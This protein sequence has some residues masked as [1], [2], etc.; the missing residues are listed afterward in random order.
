MNAS[1]YH[2][3]RKLMVLCLL[4]SALPAQAAAPVEAV[5]LFKDRV[6]VRS[7]AGQ[8]MI[9]V[10]QTSPGGVT[11]L[12]ADTQGARIE[13]QGE[14]IALSLSNR[15][16][17]TYTRPAVKTVRINQDNIGQYRTRGLING[18]YVNFLVDTGASVV[19]MSERHEQAMGLD[20]RAGEKGYVETLFGRR[21]HLGG[22]N[23]KNPSRRGFQERA[24]INA[25]IQGSAADVIRRAMVRL[26]GALAEAGLGAKMLLQVHDELIFEAPKAEVEKTCEV[27]AKI[28]RDAPT[29]AVELTVP[30]DVEASA[31]KN[32]DEAH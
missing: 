8:E 10:G 21:I 23:D 26:P 16:S 19:A 22:I 7:S 3:M 2:H 29:P 17:T 28:M 14:V 24:A 30:L 25:P 1:L 13:Y 31:G 6:V 12:E 5:A 27:V 18:H 11:L 15:V 32:W 4:G 9:R 20:Y